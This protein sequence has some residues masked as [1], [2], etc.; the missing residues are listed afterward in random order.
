M[1]GLN[2]TKNIKRRIFLKAIHIKNLDFDTYLKLKYEAEKD[3]IS[4][5]KY[6]H[7]LIHE[8]IER[9]N[10]L[11]MENHFKTRIA[12]HEELLILSSE[13]ILQMNLKLSELIQCI[14]EIFE[15]KNEGE[16]I[17]EEEKL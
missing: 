3:G 12:K 4:L 17:I 9:K 16:E 13:N 15:N 5:N 14:Y 11:E 8:H 6:M 2:Y 1:N 10:D 7:N